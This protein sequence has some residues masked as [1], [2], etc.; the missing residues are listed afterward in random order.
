VKKKI[1]SI[2]FALVLAL[3]L[4]LVTA[5][6]VAAQ[7]QLVGSFSK[8][9]QTTTTSTDF[10]LAIGLAAPSYFT[11]PHPPGASP[12]EVAN[13][14]IAFAPQYNIFQGMTPGAFLFEDI[15]FGSFSE[16]QTYTVSSVSDDLD[17]D[18]FSAFLTNGTNEQIWEA[19][20]W[21]MSTV[22][23]AGVRC[24]G[25]AIGGLFH[26]SDVF[27]G[28]DVGTDFPGLVIQSVSLTFNH[29]YTVHS[30]DFDWLTMDYTVN[31]Y[32]APPTEVWVDDD[33]TAGTPGWGLTHFATIQNGINA[34]AES[35]TV[36]VAAGTY[37]ED[38]TINKSLTLVSVAGKDNTIINGQSTGYTGAVVV[39]SGTSDVTIG[40]TGKGFTVN[41]AGQA[42]IYVV[43]SNGSITICNNKLVAT[44]GKNALLTGGGQL[45][46]TIAD[47]EFSGTASQLVY[48]NG[49][50][51]LGSANASIGVNFTNNTFSGTATGPALG[52]EATNSA[53]S[54]NTFATVTGYAALELWGT[55]NTVTGNNFTADL[56]ANG[57]YVLDNPGALNIAAALIN[58]T[59]LRAVVV[60]HNSLLPK[61]WANIQAAVNAATAGDTILVAAGT[62]TVPD[63]G[64]GIGG[65]PDWRDLAGLTLQ[66]TGTAEETIITGTASFTEGAALLTIWS[67][68]VTIDGFTFQAATDLSH[69]IG[70]VWTSSLVF[71]NNII[72]GGA[73]GM[74]I[75]HGNPTVIENNVIRNTGYVGIYT[76]GTVTIRNNSI[77]GNGGIWNEGAAGIII[78]EQTLTS[79]TIIIENNLIQDNAR[80]G[81]WFYRSS[82]TEEIH[83]NNITGND[84]GIRNEC[85]DYA[86]IAE[87]DARYNWWGDETG[88]EAILNTGAQGNAVSDKVDFSPWLYKTQETI[89][90]SREPAYAQSVVLDN[91]GAFAWNTFSTPIFLDGSADTWAELYNLTSLAYSV[92]YRFD[93]ATQNFVN[94]TT[95]DTYA[96][97]PGEG[98]FIKMNTTG[99]L[100]ILYSTE[101]NLMPSSR[102]LTVGW[103][104]IG[105]ANMEDMDVSVALFS[106]AG[107]GQVVSPTGN[108]RPG[109]V[110]AG[111]TI[112]VG[113]GYWAYML[114]ERTL[115]GFTTTPVNW[116][117]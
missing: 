103:N 70:T 4:S 68:E 44:N 83:Y 10:Y 50:A 102:P 69:S 67:S 34:V 20:I 11:P 22:N 24:A 117:P 108:V 75:S 82:G 12:V 52:Q 38:V 56:P 39:T 91:F 26:E 16:G 101:D 76:E 95:T 60:E 105:L 110:L 112:Y 73:F 35:G 81:I 5:V 92:A 79:D 25:G 28:T 7:T 88:P 115:V 19:W 90:P 54:G 47:N 87:V 85:A 40:D 74:L 51:S 33:F 66:S 116:I 99:S 114:H 32:A 9:Y 15:Q 58:N 104:L 71:K 18:D 84:Y 6:P 31:I 61:I 62:Y 97:N 42:A 96:I 59:F 55:G 80:S 94:L 30:G 93:L 1:F 65:P 113:E 45:N 37:N 2:L 98:F 3:S 109:A 23:A 13:S 17:F 107:D 106:L 46:H 77:V 48:V 8:T 41:G 86:P 49:E 111:G 14:G 57:L 63:A 100:P 64:L 27:S 72:E 36:N 53:I 43:G 29:I 21:P 78:G 89:V